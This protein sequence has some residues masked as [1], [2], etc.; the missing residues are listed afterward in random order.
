MK[1]SIWQVPR[2][3]IEMLE[4]K[5]CYPVYSNSEGVSSWFIDA[6]GN[7]WGGKRVDSNGRQRLAAVR[8]SGKGIWHAKPKTIDTHQTFYNV[9]TNR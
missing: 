7:F 4:S 2:K 5:G 9:E 1:L 8:V 6:D 3:T